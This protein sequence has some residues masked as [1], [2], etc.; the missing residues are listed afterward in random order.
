MHFAPVF[1]GRFAGTVGGDHDIQRA[2]VQLV[3]K[4]VAGPG[5]QQEAAP[6]QIVG[7]GGQQAWGHVAVEILDHAEAQGG[8]AGEVGHRQ[9]GAGL[10]G[11]VQNGLGMAAEHRACGRDLYRATG[12]VEEGSAEGGFQRGKLLA[13]GRR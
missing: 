11:G 2:G 3:K 13:N 5:F 10:G 12:A 8:E 7:E 9:L 1:G 6:F 4:P